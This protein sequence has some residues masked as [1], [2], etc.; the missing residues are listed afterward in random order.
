MEKQEQAIISVNI[1]QYVEAV[2]KWS[3]SFLRPH[4]PPNLLSNSVINRTEDDGAKLIYAKFLY[5]EKT[6][7]LS[8]IPFNGSYGTT[9]DVANDSLWEFSNEKENLPNDF[10]TSKFDGGMIRTGT[11]QKCSACRGQ[12][13]VTC[14]TCGGKV[15][16]TEKS[17][18]KYI[19]K[20][21]SCG[22]GKQLCKPCDG[23]GDVESV[24]L[25]KT[26]YK[27]YETKNSQ[28]TGE[29]PVDKIK[30]IT[31]HKIYEDIIDYP[32]DK[33]K[34]I[35]QGGINVGEF[36]QLNEAVLELLH[37]NIDSQLGGKGLKIKE[38]HKQ[39]NDL[40]KTVPN[41]GKENKLLE[42]EA[43]P[44][45]VM[46]RVEDAPV[47]QI[48]YAFKNKDYSLWVFG[49]ENAVWY[50]QLPFTINYKIL[51]IVAVVIA[52]VLFFIF[53]N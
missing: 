45:R 18:D 1:N 53:K 13:R 19:E 6:G 28:Y 32:S 8:T 41:P 37:D 34:S 21:C 22:D 48:D 52:I 16:W 25:V 2:D 9:I 40:F 24:I 10:Q 27:L 12:G 5:G 14:K 20:V 51:T 42:K 30:K 17:G 43:I 35:L 36:N 50:Q 39:V 46:V 11:V 38:I 49:N 29:V 3:N 26:E 33:V 15:R 47:T 31:G 44:I 7:K 23:Y 4:I